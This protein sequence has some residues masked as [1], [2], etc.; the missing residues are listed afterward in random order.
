MKNLIGKVVIVKA[1]ELQ[2]PLNT[3]SKWDR[4]FLCQSISPWGGSYLGVWLSD[5][6]KDDI[7]EFM[8]EEV[9]D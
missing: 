5:N 8:I 3:A 4:R 1:N 7:A 2:P 6:T 9:L